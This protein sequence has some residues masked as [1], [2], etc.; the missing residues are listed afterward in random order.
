[1]YRVAVIGILEPLPTIPKV[2]EYPRELKIELKIPGSEAMCDEAP[3]SIYQ[4]VSGGGLR[5]RP[6][7][8]A[9]NKVKACCGGF[10]AVC[11]GGGG[12][13]GG[14]GLYIGPENDAEDVGGA[15]SGLIGGVGHE[16]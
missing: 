9:P 13:Y 12:L 6:S 10:G 14:I 3:V 5:D 15:G 7:N 2:C 4:V 8:L 11:I 1:M 16:A